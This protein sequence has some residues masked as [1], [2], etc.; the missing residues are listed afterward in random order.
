MKQLP[1]WRLDCKNGLAGDAYQAFFR[2]TAVRLA[3][4]ALRR[5]SQQLIIILYAI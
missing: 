2:L 5:L 4:I 3:L 1:T